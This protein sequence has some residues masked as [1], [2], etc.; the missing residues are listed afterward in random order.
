MK[1]S[2]LLI[3]LTVVFSAPTFAADKGVINQAGVYESTMKFYL[4]PAHGFPG[5]GPRNDH[6]AVII[7]KRQSP[8]AL[9]ATLHSYKHPAHGSAATGAIFPG[10]TTYSHPI[11]AHA[12]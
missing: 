7:A 5:V 3:G 12:K 10:P 1:R 9:V 2:L 4:H 11:V 6:P 8:S